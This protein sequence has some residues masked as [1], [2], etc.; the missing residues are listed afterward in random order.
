VLSPSVEGYVLMLCEQLK[1]N[2]SQHGRSRDSS[3][4]RASRCGRRRVIMGAEADAEADAIR[5]SRSRS[6]AV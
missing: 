2:G 3:K 1:R 4:S 5:H 6:S